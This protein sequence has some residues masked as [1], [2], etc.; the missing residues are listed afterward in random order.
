MDNNTDMKLLGQRIKAR[1]EALG[2]TQEELADLLGYKSRS[3]LNKIELGIQ[4]LRQSKIKAVAF[5]S[6]IK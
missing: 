2:M 3:S 5:Q 4:G 6:Y 1:R